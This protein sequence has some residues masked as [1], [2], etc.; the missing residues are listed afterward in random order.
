MVE[1]FKTLSSDTLYKNPYW[2]YKYDKYNMP[3]GRAGEYFY[4]ETPG[5][6]MVIPLL[7]NGRIIL[8]K[9]YRYLNKRFSFEFPGGGIK[10]T[11]GE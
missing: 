9:Q 11:D 10:T 4:V 5:S 2:E 7:D 1:K 8:V 3:S 6:V